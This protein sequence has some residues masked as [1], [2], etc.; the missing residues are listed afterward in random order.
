MSSQPWAE[1]LPAQTGQHRKGQLYVALAALAWS[2]AGVL[3]R[4]LSVPAATQLAGRAAFAAVALAAYVVAVERS[5]P[6]TT[7]RALTRAGFAMA[8]CMAVSSGAFIF[9]LNYTTVANV[10]FTQAV[11]PFI[12]ALLGTAFLAE[13]VARRTWAAMVVALVGVGL[14]V[15][16]PG[17]V[18]ALGEGL[19]LLMATA[20]AAMLVITRHR[21]DVSMAPATCLSQLMVLVVA[22]P[23]T[24]PGQIGSRDLV[25]MASMGVGQ[26][27]LG[28]ALLTVGARLIPAAEIALIT[29]L[30]VVLGPLW[31]WIFRSE[32]PAL[33]TLAGGAVVIVAVVIQAVGNELARASS[34]AVARL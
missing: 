17:G 25:L 11:S 34:G 21:R 22:G 32:R 33:S 30:E 28:L 12:A 29:L 27:G 9:A 20:F 1:P 23:F 3:Q 31:V 15:G 7:A 2:S 24:H 14:M 4:E 19:S 10:L 8:A 26:I 18:D 5:S 16:G 13:P 6:A